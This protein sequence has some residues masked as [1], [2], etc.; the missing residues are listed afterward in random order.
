[1]R[2]FTNVSLKSNSPLLE[3]RMEFSTYFLWC[4]SPVVQSCWH[5]SASIQCINLRCCINKCLLIAL[6]EYKYLFWRYILAQS[7]QMLEWHDIG[8]LWQHEKRVAVFN[9]STCNYF[10][11]KN[12]FFLNVII[13]F[14]YYHC[15]IMI[16][17][18][19][20]RLFGY[21]SCQVRVKTHKTN[22]QQLY[23]VIAKYQCFSFMVAVQLQMSKSLQVVLKT[24]HFSKFTEKCF[25]SKMFGLIWGS[26]YDE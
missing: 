19:V 2:E 3:N 26:R 22:Q 11:I 9:D 14:S 13:Q 24:Y 23:N 7:E 16:L 17:L 6:G 10:R 1:M 15:I 21:S 18:G 8:T 4:L 5:F 20:P 12:H 25:E